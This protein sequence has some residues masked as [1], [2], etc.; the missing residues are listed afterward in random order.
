M[1]LIGV[2]F[3]I[4]A[5]LFGIFLGGQCFMTGFSEVVERSRPL[6]AERS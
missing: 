2:I 4:I 6:E 5:F 3:A 1:K